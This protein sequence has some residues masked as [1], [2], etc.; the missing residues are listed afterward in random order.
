MKRILIFSVL[1]I[2][3]SFNSCKDRGGIF[4]TSKK[5]DAQIAN[6]EKENQAL[7]SELE[8]IEGQHQAE[9]TEI[10]SDYEQKLANLQK[11]IEAGTL[12][13]YDAYYVIVGSFKND[14]YAQ[15]YSGKIKELGY[16]G[17]IIPGPN[18]FNLVTYGTYSTLKSSLEPMRQAREKVAPA[19]W[20]YFKN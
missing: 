19:A 9:I 16:E 15:E 5:T 2:L 10:R 18:D 3:I 6:L 17:K 12:Q 7:R 8:D 14:N 1:V 13:E 4:G 11:Q 20:I